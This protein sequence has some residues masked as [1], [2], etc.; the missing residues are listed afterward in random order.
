M[1]QRDM[2]FSPKG[3]EA[4]TRDLRSDLRSEGGI[5][6]LRH[7][8]GNDLFGAATGTLHPIDQRRVQRHLDVC[9]ECAR[10][11]NAFQE[12][13]Q[14][15]EGADGGKRLEELRN[16]LRRARQT[17]SEIVFEAGNNIGSGSSP[18]AT[19]SGLRDQ[20]EQLVRKI[21][22]DAGAI[23]RECDYTL[24]CGLHSDTHI[25]L[26]KICRRES[27]LA[28]IVS[29]LDEALQGETFDT[30]VST[31]WALAMIARRL[32][33][34][35]RTQM[36]RRIRHV[37]VEGYD[38][39]TVLE[40]VA[41]GARVILL[42]DVVVTGGQ[43][44]RVTEELRKQK[45]TSVKSIA[46]VDADFSGRCVA[47]IERLCRIAMDLARPG[48]CRRCGMLPSAE[49]N[50]IAG[51]M[52]KKKVQPRSPSEFLNNDSVAREL[53]ESVNT[54]AAFEH[55]RI[56]GTR[57]YLGF[58]DTAALLRHPE[59]GPLVVEKLCR[60]IEARSGVPDVVLVPARARG[61]LF[62][63]CL[64][65]GFEQFLGVSGVCLER[66]RQQAG[67]FTLEG[68]RDLSGVRVLVAD[69]AAGHGDTL[70]ELALLSS[71]AGAASVAGVVLLSRLSE[72]CE[73]SF[74]ERLSGGFV[75]LYSMPVRP[76]TVRDKNR[77]NC[78]VCQRRQALKQAV[79]ELPAGRVREVAKKLSAGPRFRRRTVPAAP[80][81]LSGERQNA[82]FPLGP[83]STC[84]PGVAS[85]IALHA[86]HAAMGDGM[87]P[88]SLPEIASNNIPSA[89]RAALVA[90]LPA[91]VL[92]W[93]GP[94][95]LEQLCGF[96]K[97]GRDR[98][99]WTAI[100]ELMSRSGST[101]WVDCLGDAISNAETFDPWMDDQF[102]ARMILVV[103]RLARGRP[104]TG[105]QMRP[106]LKAL[107]ETYD[108]TSVHL[109]L[110]GMLKATY[111][112]SD[113]DRSVRDD[114]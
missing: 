86:L 56:V 33:L 25:N 1:T 71:S 54:A 20:R 93:S 35:R 9:T 68:V 109:G 102:W 87:A 18:N 55:H 27:S 57:H 97:R 72:V 108:R 99:V 36:R 78:S 11:I 67:H 14:A 40:E 4:L 74:D 107:V 76:I 52:T 88:L 114:S 43:V 6:D 15:W 73:K 83:L 104:G 37:M 42:L 32:V 62:G 34:R 7:P 65:G 96:L 82:L 105:D 70:D 53:W 22:N 94:P 41:P 98:D 110:E 24:P 113:Y 46:I 69:A 106:L 16:R 91:G 81:T 44:L 10:R 90:D 84:R 79:A 49:F 12:T 5:K 66:V 3:L 17:Q 28:A 23:E 63:G 19:T 30:V 29:A 60:R 13:A 75:R 95:L 59:T 101:D 26:G 64:V 21:L 50:P 111:D 2:Q 58:V 51:R 80:S 77:M 100:V 39:P 85:G 103:H 61:V 89:K 31:G 48:E 47:T 112:P 38:P 45:A 92:K 8:G